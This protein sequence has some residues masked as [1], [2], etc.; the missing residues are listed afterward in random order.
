MINWKIIQLILI[1]HFMCQIHSN[2]CSGHMYSNVL[3]EPK[4]SNNKLICKHFK[5]ILTA[6]STFPDQLNLKIK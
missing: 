3:Y 1:N 4:C 5:H 2:D 6:F